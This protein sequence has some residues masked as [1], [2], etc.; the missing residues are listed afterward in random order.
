MDNSISNLLIL[1]IWHDLGI[2]VSNYPDF[3]SDYYNYGIEVG[4][5]IL[6]KGLEDLFSDFQILDYED[7]ERI[8][9][10]S[11][12]ANIQCPPDT[13]FILN[14]R[15]LQKLKEHGEIEK[16]FGVI[17]K[18]SGDLSEFKMAYH[19]EYGILIAVYYES[20][21]YEIAKSVSEVMSAADT[22]YK[23]LEEVTFHGL[24]NQAV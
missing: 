20:V 8:K 18:Q 5:D 13:L 9:E 19:V 22:L 12:G 6:S 4:F 10:M 15:K 2:N 11:K 1:K 21:L 16:L 24:Y 3:M 7:E 23:N 14:N 17:S